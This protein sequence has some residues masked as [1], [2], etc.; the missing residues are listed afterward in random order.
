MHLAP[1]IPPQVLESKVLALHIC[2]PATASLLE[3][4]V[5][6]GVVVKP[7]GAVD[8]EVAVD[9][10][11]KSSN[12]GLDSCSTQSRSVIVLMDLSSFLF[13]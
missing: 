6:L 5:L 11:G 1:A 3:T 13:S 8:G 9:R 12:H 10:A 4:R 7:I 2:S